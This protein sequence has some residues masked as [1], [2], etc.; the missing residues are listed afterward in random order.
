MSKNPLFL[1]AKG[2]QCAK[3]VLWM[4]Q[5]GKS[6]LAPGIGLN[7]CQLFSPKAKSERAFQA[8]AFKVSSVIGFVITIILLSS[9]PTVAY[10]LDK[11]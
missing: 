6:T 4:T 10:I 2:L 7:V 8:A 5:A 3:W 11:I 1:K 9:Q